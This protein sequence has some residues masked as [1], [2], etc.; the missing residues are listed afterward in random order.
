MKVPL[1]RNPYNYDRNQASDESGLDCSV[2][3]VGRAKQSFKDEADI[4]TIV[5][6]FGLDGEL[7]VGVRMPVYGD[8]LH[9]NDFH[10]AAN[11]IA[12]A[13][14]SFDALPARVRARFN[15]EPGE[16][17]DFCLARSDDGKELRNLAELRSLGLVPP[18]EAKAAPVVVPS[19]LT[20]NPPARSSEAVLA[21]PAVVAP[22]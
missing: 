10:Q 1:M 3:G 18:G 9:V 16:F 4:N 6:R 5:R 22:Q 7:P 8:F 21:P 15:N 17:V 12:L 11:S 19:Q 20:V 13:N 14:E 2:D